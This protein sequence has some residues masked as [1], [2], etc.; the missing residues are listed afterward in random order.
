VECVIGEM[1]TVVYRI[2]IIRFIILLPVYDSA[3]KVAVVMIMCC[4]LR[5]SRTSVLNLFKN[6]VL[7]PVK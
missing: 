3:E 2:L 4:K 7:W 5:S 6:N 1:L